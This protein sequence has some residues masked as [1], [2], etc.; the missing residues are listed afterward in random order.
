VEDGVE[1]VS[2]G[3]NPW[4]RRREPK[5]RTCKLEA[6]ADWCNDYRATVLRYACQPMPCERVVSATQQYPNVSC[7][8]K[9]RLADLFRQAFAA[10]VLGELGN[11]DYRNPYK[12]AMTSALDHCAEEYYCTA[13][14]ENNELRV[15]IPDPDPG[16]LKATIKRLLDRTARS[17]GS[18]NSISALDDDDEHSPEEAREILARAVEECAE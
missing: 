2:Y 10:S 8:N 16:M 17:W 12:Y 14:A 18:P 4:D 7:R 13:C 5:G 9:K 3:H 11:G 15:A 1:R 6:W